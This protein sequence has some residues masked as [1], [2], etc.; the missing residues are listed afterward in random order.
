MKNVGTHDEENSKDKCCVVCCFSIIVNYN[1]YTNA[2]PGLYL[3]YKL[4]L[5]F[6]INQVGC[7][8]TFS[9][10]KYVKNYLRNTLSQN[11]LESFILMSVEKEILNKI[12]PYDI[13]DKV[14]IQ[15]ETLKKKLIY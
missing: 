11:H 2:Y 4:L 1:L 8:R 14:A 5:T 9:K 10:L 12:N 7:E 15:S 13:I 3:A 6:S